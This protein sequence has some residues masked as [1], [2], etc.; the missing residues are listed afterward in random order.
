MASTEI[1]VRVE[2]RDTKK[3][4]AV[5]SE[6]SNAADCSRISAG[7][8]AIGFFEQSIMPKIRMDE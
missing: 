6:K 3:I 8:L 7:R 5:G 2:N 4:H 1:N